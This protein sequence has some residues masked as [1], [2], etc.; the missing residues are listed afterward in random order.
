MRADVTLPEITFK[1]FQKLMLKRKRSVDELVDIFRGKIEDSRGFFDRAMTCQWRNPKTGRYEDRSQVVVPYRS[2]IEF[3]L[4][5]VHYLGD[6]KKRPMKISDPVKMGI[7]T[8]ELI[9]VF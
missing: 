4:K 8:R 3:Y 6:S 1:E 2:V 9:E 7:P 5:E